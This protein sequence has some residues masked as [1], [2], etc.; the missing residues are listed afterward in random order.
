EFP[1]VFRCYRPPTPT[2]NALDS[3]PGVRN[4]LTELGLDLPRRTGDTGNSGG[5][6][7]A[8]G[9]EVSSGPGKRT[10]SF[11][12]SL[13]A[14]AATAM[15]A[16][17]GAVAAAVAPAAASATS[18]SLFSSSQKRKRRIQKEDGDDTGALLDDHVVPP[19]PSP[20]SNPNP[21]GP[22]VT[23]GAGAATGQVWASSSGA[24]RQAKGKQ[25][26]RGGGGAGGTGLG[27]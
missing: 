16:G 1:V 12:L 20:V 2:D 25:G 5:G 27:M 13:P 14:S 10:T 3:T 21:G 18:A 8:V 7:R 26:K 24:L 19:N 4:L 22:G 17:V 23:V 11:P 9:G 6:K 15:A